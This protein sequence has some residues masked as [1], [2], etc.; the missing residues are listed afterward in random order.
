VPYN[1]EADRSISHSSPQYLDTAC[2]GK[3]G[4]ICVPVITFG[5]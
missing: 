2:I 3:L 4:V 1:K 5:I